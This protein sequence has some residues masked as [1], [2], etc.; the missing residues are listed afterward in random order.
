MASLDN[1]NIF[2]T[3]HRQLPAALRNT[4]ISLFWCLS[5]MVHQ[6]EAVLSCSMCPSNTSHL[7]R[8]DEKWCKSLKISPNR[9]PSSHS[10][11]SSSAKRLPILN[12]NRN[13]SRSVE[14]N[15][16]R[17]AFAANF[18]PT[19]INPVSGFDF[20]QPAVAAAALDFPFHCGTLFVLYLVCSL[21]LNFI[22]CTKSAQTHFQT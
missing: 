3:L 11:K 5:P 7:S 9:T 14:P 6:L 1:V 4:Y 18:A 22:Q 19:M 12:R 20:R 8:S 16:A 21:T 13:F 2:L 10:S 15:W 17:N